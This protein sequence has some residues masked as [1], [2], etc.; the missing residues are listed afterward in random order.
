MKKKTW[1]LPLVALIA[2]LVGMLASDWRGLLYSYDVTKS[3]SEQTEETSEI[4][5]VPYGQIHSTKGKFQTGPQVKGAPDFIEEKVKEILTKPEEYNGE[6][7]MS[8]PDKGFSN[9]T[10]YQTKNYDKGRFLV[11]QTNRIT[12]K[13]RMYT[14][15]YY[16]PSVQDPIINWSKDQ[17]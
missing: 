7:Q 10:Y 13:K 3:F 11:I 4:A 8:G 6:R 17:L 9:R 16:E 12:G 14:G 1:L 15:T 5:V 2:G